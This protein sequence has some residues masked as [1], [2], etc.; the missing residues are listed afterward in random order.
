[1]L[2]RRARRSSSPAV[3]A[4]AL[5][6]GAPALVRAQTQLFPL[7]PIQR[8]R[9]P[10]PMEDPVYGLYRQ[11]YYGYFPTCWRQFPNGW[12]CPSPEAPNAARA[13]QEQPRD[14]PPELP[15]P[16]EGRDLLPL[17][18]EAP[19]RPGRG[20]TPPPLPSGERSP[21]DIDT[22]PNPNAPG[23]APAP[24]PPGSGPGLGSRG[25]APAPPTARVAPRPVPAP[26]AP[27]PVERNGGEPPVL[28]LPDPAEI[29][30]IAPTEAGTLPG[31]GIP[32]TTMNMNPGP[33]TGPGPGLAPPAIET[34]MAVPNG[35]PVQ[36]PQR[37]GPLSSLFNGMA[38][39]IRR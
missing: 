32:G 1:M 12:G 20:R 7:A 28:A 4:A 19:A 24:A 2:K 22:P 9:V 16:E 23:S 34:P 14:K 31:P 35:I 17:P 8:P 29:G 3:W 18:G 26:A 11:Q 5:V 25:L 36:A 15:E 38:S 10:C 33:G 37:R 39:R 13:F 21:F 27:A 30:P 6:L